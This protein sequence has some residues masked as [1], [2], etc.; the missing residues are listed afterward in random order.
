[1]LTSIPNS[2][3][4]QDPPNIANEGLQPEQ[5]TLPRVLQSCATIH[6][7]TTNFVITFFADRIFII[8]TQLGKI[9]SLVCRIPT[10]K[11]FF[12]QLKS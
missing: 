3:E 11:F 9:G 8:V 12:D 10:T 5:S 2:I 1:M 4:T 6:N 7:Q